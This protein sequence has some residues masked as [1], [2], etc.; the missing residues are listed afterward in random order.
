MNNGNQKIG[1]PPCRK[2][3][4]IP[5][6]PKPST[7]LI[8]YEL[9]AGDE[10]SRYSWVLNNA[11]AVEYAPFSKSLSA[12]Y[13]DILPFINAGIPVRFHTRYPEWEI[14]NADIHASKQALKVHCD[15]I[16][17]I[18]GLG[19]PVLTVHVGLNRNTQL[20]YSKVKE[21]LCRLTDYAG[22]RGITINLENLRTGI[23]SDPKI[24]L[25]LT[26]ASG[27]S[28]TF[29]VGHAVSSEKVNSGA[30]TVPGIIK[31]F[32]SKINGVHIYS[33]EENGCHRPIEDAFEMAPILDSL[34]SLSC[35]WWTVELKDCTQAECTKK[36]LVDYINKSTS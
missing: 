20:D 29:D 21:N 30:F 9:S 35:Y 6:L 32:S 16:D 19:E 14:G 10:H 17:K 1:K 11:I 15:T 12:I 27:A 25:D 2:A 7:P 18:Q 31:M 22:K 34:L 26:E 28:I 5:A 23:T 36:I 4:D 33:K 13:S 8:A 24:M 3:L